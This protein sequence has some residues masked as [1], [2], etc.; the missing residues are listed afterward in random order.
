MSFEQYDPNAKS[1]VKDND[2]IEYPELPE[3]YRWRVSK[4]ATYDDY[5]GRY[6]DWKMELMIQKRKRVKVSTF[7]FPKL[8]KRWETVHSEVVVRLE[9]NRKGQIV[10]SYKP[11]P[12]ELELRT[13]TERSIGRLKDQFDAALAFEGEVNSFL[14]AAQKVS[15]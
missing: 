6:D 5:Y 12:N 2:G 3:G 1:G 11:I 4:G 10:D 13:R 9:T 14:A 7:L 15:A 8:V